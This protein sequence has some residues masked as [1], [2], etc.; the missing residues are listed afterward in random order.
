M[1]LTDTVL[2]IL[3]AKPARIYTVTPD[4]TVYDAL[5]TMA[6][7]E[8]GSLLVVSKDGKLAGIV[9]ERDYARKVILLGKSSRDTTVRDIMR[10]DDLSVT[11]NDTIDECMRLMT[12]NRVR[13]LPVVDGS[14]ICGVVSI[15]DLVN[16]IISAQEE[17]IAHLH[18]Y[19]AADYPR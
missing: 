12:V 2:A 3:Q 18:A 11:T 10:S 19:V 16:W 5:Q 1:N 6:N 15:G 9:S 8:V 14:R 7:K 4:T 17:T 13:H